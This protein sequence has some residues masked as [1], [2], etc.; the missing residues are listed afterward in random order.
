MVDE[1][2]S[3]VVLS[4]VMLF[5]IYATDKLSPSTNSGLLTEESFL[6]S[7]N[8]SKK[9]GLVERWNADPEWQSFVWP[10][11]FAVWIGV[12]AT[13]LIAFYN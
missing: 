13:L 11:L 2:K 9:K 1:L 7:K 10:P 4:T 6:N 12:V 5:R 3:T 8:T